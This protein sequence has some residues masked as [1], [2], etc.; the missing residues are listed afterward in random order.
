M[1]NAIPTGIERIKCQLA[2][3]QTVA[4][5]PS[6][7]DSVVIP[8]ASANFVPELS[9]CETVI[10]KP[11]IHGGE[12]EDRGNVIV[13]FANQYLHSNEIIPSTTQEEIIFSVRP[14][15]FSG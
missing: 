9:K 1:L 6:L 11:V 10:P 12:G 15:A 8:R 14:V 7:N 5:L 13:D 2:Y 4:N 3:F